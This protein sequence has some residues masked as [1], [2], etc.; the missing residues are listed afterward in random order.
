MK[1]GNAVLTTKIKRPVVGLKMRNAVELM[2]TDT[3][4]RIKYFY[5]IPFLMHPNDRPLHRR[6]VGLS[7]SSLL[8]LLFIR[9]SSIALF[10]C[11]SRYL[12]YRGLKTTN[13]FKKPCNGNVNAAIKLNGKLDAIFVSVGLPSKGTIRTVK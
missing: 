12:M 13:A 6:L 8:M 9:L 5:L 10:F 2:V 7:S 3:L 4:L 1:G 11:S